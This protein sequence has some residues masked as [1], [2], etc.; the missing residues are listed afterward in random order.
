[1][2]LLMKYITAI[3][4]IKKRHYLTPLPILI[5]SGS[6]L[7]HWS[8]WQR[9]GDY[10]E[11][12]VITHILYFPFI[13]WM[14][15]LLVVCYPHANNWIQTTWIYNKIFGSASFLIQ[16]F[17]GFSR[18]AEIDRN[19]PDEYVTRETYLH[20]TD[21]RIYRSTYLAEPRGGKR[22]KARDKQLV[23]SVFFIFKDIFLRI[24]VHFGIL[25]ISPILFLIAVPRLDKKGYLESL[26]V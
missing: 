14:T 18:L 23:Y 21:G 3:K 26:E 15:I 12:G 6:I 13:Y 8:D 7:S 17:F 9:R 20:G 25:L 22:Y 4:N 11:N 16:S 5:V 24:F 1:M 10:Y 19:T 2:G